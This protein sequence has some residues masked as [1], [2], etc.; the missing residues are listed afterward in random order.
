[1]NEVHKR[2]IKRIFKNEKM[3]ELLYPLSVSLFFYGLTLIIYPEIMNTYEVYEIVTNIVSPLIFGSIFI[4][5]SIGM[6]LSY[7]FKIKL[8]LVIFSILSL[9][10]SAMFTVS[11]IIADPP[12]TVWILTALFTYMSLTLIRRL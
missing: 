7:K 9:S 3:K 1:M 6:L 10:L 2:D 11:F 5:L 4:F 8:L 12:N